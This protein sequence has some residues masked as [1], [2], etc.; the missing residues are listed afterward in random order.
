MAPAAARPSTPARPAQPLP[1]RPAPPVRN[2]RLPPERAQRVQSPGYFPELGVLVLHIRVVDGID[3][4][5]LTPE[6]P[7]ADVEAF[8]A[9]PEAHEGLASRN[10]CRVCRGRFDGNRVVLRGVLQPAGVFVK[11]AENQGGKVNEVRF[12]PL[13]RFSKHLF[14]LG[15]PVRIV[16][17][18]VNDVRETQAGFDEQW[19]FQLG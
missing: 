1:P 10:G 3:A 19:I 16:Q 9:A 14:Y 2:S 17:V 8:V 4:G 13:L 6:H 15:A 18:D 12:V 5:S 11:L 7:P